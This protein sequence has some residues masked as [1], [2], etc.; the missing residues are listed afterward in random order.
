MSPRHKRRAQL[1]LA[2][3]LLWLCG[4]EALPALHEGL[5]GRLAAHRH[6]HGSIVTASFEDSTHRHPDGS[7]HFVA[8]KPA[9]PR[10]AAD[11]GRV[12]DDGRPR[13]R[14]LASHAAGL[15]HHAEA[16]AP[17]APPV[18]APL[19]VDRRPITLA[20]ERAVAMVSL[21]PLAPSARGPPIAAFES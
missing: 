18:T 12:R 15:A 3:V 8:S 9:K 16:I 13:A 1:A 2:G 11:A 14:D 7:I 10:K 21:D 20:V 19:P 17:A 4:V 5:H 6:E